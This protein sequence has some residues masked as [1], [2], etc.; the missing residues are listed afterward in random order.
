MLRKL[1]LENL[2]TFDL[3]QAVSW[4]IACCSGVFGGTHGEDIEEFGILSID[5]SWG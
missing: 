4:Y 5:G 2:V 3:S 1:V